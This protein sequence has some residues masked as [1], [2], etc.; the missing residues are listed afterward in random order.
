LPRSQMQ[1]PLGGSP[2]RER[3]GSPS[4]STVC[5]CERWALGGSRKLMPPGAL[6]LGGGSS[7]LSDARCG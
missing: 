6:S 3:S 4:W 2:S 7:C 1:R 5:H